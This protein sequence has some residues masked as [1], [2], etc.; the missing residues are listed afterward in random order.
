[1]VQVQK[2]TE[3]YLSFRT[4]LSLLVFV[5]VRLSLLGITPL[6]INYFSPCDGR[7]SNLLAIYYQRMKGTYIANRFGML[8]GWKIRIRGYSF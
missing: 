7:G 8:V 5:A 1:M 6:I 2:A 3:R 4:L